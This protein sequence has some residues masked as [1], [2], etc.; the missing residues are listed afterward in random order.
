MS[1]YT[2]VE[3]DELEAFLGYYELGDLLDY[4]GISAGIENTN[5]FVTTSEKRLV[6]TLFENHSAAELGYFLDLMAFLAEH[7]VPS[8]HP[9]ADRDGHFL[10]ELNGKPA[11][12]VMRL[13]GASVERPSAAQCSALGHALG[14]L[15]LSGQQFGGRRDNDRGPHW[16][17]TTRDIVAARLSDADR[18]LLDEELAFQRSH[19]FDSLPRGVIHADLFRDNALFEGDTLTGII[20]F[21][22]ACND[23]LL[24]D[25]AVTA[26]DWCSNADGSLDEA[27]LLALLSAY[28]QV[29]PFDGQEPEAWP[30][31]LRAGAL[32][33]WLSRLQD[34]Y[35]PREGE[36]TH[37]KD[38]EVFK[39]ILLQRKAQ[40]ARLQEL[41]HRA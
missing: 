36:L 35:F 1:V 4:Q 41:F 33:F 21:Y 13:T 10:R 39:A 23:V 24:Y 14:Q 26:N 19:R 25:V 22:Y 29:R 30:V 34:L 38:P 37:T 3:R 6:L 2:P 15:H 20:D 7:D 9:I 16:W 28:R 11:A 18:L 31:M 8:A 12:F 40:A 5:Y 27:K 17:L 32:R